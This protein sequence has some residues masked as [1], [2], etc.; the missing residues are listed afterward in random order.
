[1]VG[2]RDLEP[3]NTDTGFRGSRS[4]L[5]MS[6]FILKC[7]GALFWVHSLLPILKGSPVVESKVRNDH[8]IPIISFYE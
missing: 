2:L 6:D 5:K 8:S 1:M 4:P 7:K 3:R